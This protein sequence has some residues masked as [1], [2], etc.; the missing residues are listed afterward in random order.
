[1]LKNW[2]GVDLGEPRPAPTLERLIVHWNRIEE[3]LRGRYTKAGIDRGRTF[4][5]EEA[6]GKSRCGRGC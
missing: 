6:L 5:W 2:F 4:H 1:M 3:T